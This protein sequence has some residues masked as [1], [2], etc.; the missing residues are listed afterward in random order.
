MATARKQASGMWKVRVYHY[1]DENGKQHYKSF[2]G[3]TKKEAEQ[4][5]LA[6]TASTNQI[7]DIT[8]GEAV[9]RYIESKYNVLSPSTIS[10]YQMIERNYFGLIKNTKLSKL[11]NELLQRQLDAVA[12]DHAPKTVKNVRGL[13]TSTLKMFPVPFIID[14]KGSAKEKVITAIPTEDDIQKI[15]SAASGEEIEIAIL[16]AAFG[17]LRRGEVCALCPDCIHNTYITVRRAIVMKPDRT[18]ELRSRPKTFAGYRDVPLPA[19]IIAKLKKAAFGKKKT[20]PIITYTPNGLYKAFCRITK[21]AGVYPYKFHSLRHY[22]A[23]FSHAIGIPDQYIMEIGGWDDIGTLAKIYRHTMDSQKS[24][25]ADK[26]SKYY[27]EIQKT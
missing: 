14:I 1:Q 13:I 9:H 26:I 20:E 21:K 11:T 17:S 19:D 8:F 7:K 5:A 16:L 12:A 27:S 4:K 22:F 24:I 3:R 25:A 2:T 23:T 6:F 18:W 10:G 15:L